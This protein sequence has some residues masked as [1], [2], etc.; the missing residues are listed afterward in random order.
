MWLIEYVFKFTWIFSYNIKLS[1]LL[2]GLQATEWGQ[3][4]VLRSSMPLRSFT[5]LA[6]KKTLKAIK[7]YI[8]LF[9]SPG[10]LIQVQPS[11]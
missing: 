1:V 6:E 10:A 11:A 7:V 2:I 9:T 8:E 4:E 3:P 5:H